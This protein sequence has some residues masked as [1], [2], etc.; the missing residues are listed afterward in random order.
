[1]SYTS[2]LHPYRA[3]AMYL[4]TSSTA[5]VPLGLG[6]KAKIS[7]FVNLDVGYQVNFTNTDNLDG[8]VSGPT[9]DRFS[10]SHIGLEFALGQRSKPQMASISKAA[11]M[12][13]EYAAREKLLRNELQAQQAELDERKKASD[14]LQ[15]D[16]DAANAGLAKV[17]ADSDGDGV[18]DYFDKCPNTPAS[19]KVDGSGCP[20]AEVKPI[21]KG[22]VTDDDKKIAAAAAKDLEFYSG[23]TVIVGYSFTGLNKL[24]QL[25]KDKNLSIKIDCYTD[26]LGDANINLKFSQARA[27]AVKAYL[28]I[29]GVSSSQIEATGYGEAKPIASNKTAS[30]RKLNNRIEL[31]L[32]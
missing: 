18:P 32:F 19:T 16:L 29:K 26:N 27:D 8:Y 15:N 10:Y 7:S 14:K 3:D 2:V 20:V 5:F 22:S 28:V 23:T 12:Q 6:F 21:A 13:N 30:G 25:M 31:T 17:N 11:A 24:A 4:P 9:N 1:M